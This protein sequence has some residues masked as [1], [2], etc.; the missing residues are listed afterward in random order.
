MILIGWSHSL[1]QT[2]LSNRSKTPNHFIA[3]R[4]EPHEHSAGNLRNSAASVTFEDA[5]NKGTQ[6]NLYYF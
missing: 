5:Q 1:D 6:T 4:F 2:S 3:V